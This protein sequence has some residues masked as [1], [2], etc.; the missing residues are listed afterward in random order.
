M[1]EITY[2]WN[3]DYQIPDIGLTP[4][5][6]EPLG[7]YGRMRRSFLKEHR[8]IL[9]DSLTLTEELFPHLYEVQRN[10][11]ARVGL[12]MEELLKKNP[13][14]DKMADQMGWVCHMNSLK[15]QAE[16]VVLDEL[17]YN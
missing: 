14:P 15:A 13:P 16:E 6:A 9:Y 12:I 5:E 2:T 11:S 8:P 4:V 3:G 1:V 10:A 17:I 7:K